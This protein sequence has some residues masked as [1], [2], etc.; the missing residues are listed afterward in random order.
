MKRGLEAKIRRL[1]ERESKA[2]ATKEWSDVLSTMEAPPF[3]YRFDHVTQTVQVAKYLAKETGADLDVV[4][5]AAWLHDVARPGIIIPDDALPLGEEGAEIAREFLLAERVDTVM[6]DR[7]CEVIQKHVGYTQKAP[8]EPLEAQIVWEA[9]KLTKI[10][11]VN[12]V[13]FIINNIRFEPN[14]STES[15]LH[16]VP[17]ILSLSREIAACMHTEPAKR[18]A[19][20]WI[21]NIEFFI[22]RLE[23]EL[24]L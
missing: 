3:N 23:S 6:V 20:A 1:V 7:V 24:N 14:T 2:K 17:E 4:V 8:L 15:I 11:L 12:I 16:R 18:L 13:R 10:G 19:R 9:D 22:D 5:M 21:Q